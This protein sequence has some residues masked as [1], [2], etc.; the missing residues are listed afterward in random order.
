VTH[1]SASSCFF[2]MAQQQPT[3]YFSQYIDYMYS[4]I[5]Q[6]L[7]CGIN[8][9]CF[10]GTFSSAP[11]PSLPI[12]TNTEPPALTSKAAVDRLIAK[13]GLHEYWLLHKYVFSAPCNRL[14]SRTRRP[15]WTDTHPIDITSQWQV[16][17]RWSTPPMWSIMW[18]TPLSGNQ[19]SNCHNDTGTK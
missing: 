9:D 12:L 7:V 16:I 1:Y 4:S 10:T 13:T 17:G 8:N 19:D 11:L 2:A 18:M 5:L 6:H 15:L 3:C 14:P